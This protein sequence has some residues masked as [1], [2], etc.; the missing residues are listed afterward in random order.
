[1]NLSAAVELE[2]PW[3]STLTG[4][5]TEPL[6]TIGNASFSASGLIKLF[7]FLALLGLSTHYLRQALLRRV[8]PRARIDPG[9]AY[10]IG[11]L[12]TYLFI[13]IGLLVGLQAAGIDLSTLTV[14]FGAIG[15]GVGFGIQTIASNFISGLIILFEQPIRVGDRI[16]VG[17]LDGR[18]IRIRARATE[19]LTNSEISVLVPN[20][21]FISQRVINWSLGSDKIRMSVPIRVAYGSD[22]E[23]VRTALLEAAASVDVVLED[24]PPSVRLKA[25]AD[26][27]IEFELLCWTREM[28]QSPRAFTSRMNFAI[29]ATLKSHDLEIPFPQR[30]VRF[31][32]GDAAPWGGSPVEPA[33]QPRPDSPL[34][35]RP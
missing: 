19:V 2:G 31:R 34:K 10:A 9:T 29:H 20:S 15:V 12:A 16:Q 6:F 24:P 18:V 35:D 23:K 8:F 33:H 14:L 32:G 28:L 17:D 30:E 26:S 3:L 21:E 27:G 13:A 5:L 7:I 4:W 1:M 11:N 25:F 22:V